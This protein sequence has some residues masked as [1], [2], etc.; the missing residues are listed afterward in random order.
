MI[1]QRHF[2]L[3]ALAAA[4]AVPAGSAVAAGPPIA[5]AKQAG[6]GFDLYLTNPNG[7]GTIKL[8]SGPAKNSLSVDMNPQLSGGLNELAIVE[9]RSTGFKIIRYN[10]A[11]GGRTVTP[12]DDPCYIDSLDYHPSNGSLLV[13]R[14]CRNPQWV[15]VR[16]WTNGTYGPAILSTDGV[17]DSYSSARWLGDGSGFLVRYGNV[18]SGTEIQRRNLSNPSAPTTVWSD[19]Y[20]SAAL[21]LD[22]ARC[23]GALDSSCMKFLYYDGLVLREVQFDDAGEV[24]DNAVVTG[25][26]GRYSPNNSRVLYRTEVKGGYTL[27]V[28]NPDQ[29]AAAKAGTFSGMD[30]RP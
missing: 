21:S 13:V 10:D 6:A 7:S 19:P 2:S 16:V 22:T 28:T 15:E 4:I 5:Y 1:D 26:G 14:S 24:S 9:S 12:V 23:S 11:G 20:L 30:W 25:W 8:Y 3:V 18:A 17:N 27:K 29:T